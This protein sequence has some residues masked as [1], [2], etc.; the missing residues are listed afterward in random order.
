MYSSFNHEDIEITDLEG[1]KHFLK[2]WDKLNPDEEIKGESMLKTYGIGKESLTFEDW[3]DVKLISYWYDKDLVFL[4]CIAKFIEGYVSWTFE[5]ADEGGSVSFEK[6]QC[7]IT[8][9]QM[10][11][12]DWKPLSQLR[13]EITNKKLKK[14]M[15]VCKL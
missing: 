6:G 13:E 8:T 12:T 14:L 7:T 15:I 2:E 4:D 10:N 5:N 11:W 3:D 9:G 1:L